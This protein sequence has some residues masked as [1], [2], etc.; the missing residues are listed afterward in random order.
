MKAIYI[1]LTLILL[2]SCDKSEKR[3]EKKNAS[4][5]VHKNNLGEDDAVQK[6]AVNHYFQANGGTILYLKNGEIKGCA[7]CD[8]DGDLITELLK[9]E[10]Y[11]TYK[12]YDNYLVDKTNDTLFFFDDYGKILPDWKIL[13]GV[14]VTNNSMVISFFP[15][16]KTASE[17]VQKITETCLVIFNP[18]VK[19]FEDEN[20][21]EAEAYF[22][23][24]DDWNWYSHELNEYFKKRNVQTI[25]ATGP[26]SLA[27]E[28]N[29]MITIDPKNKINNSNVNAILY[30]KRKRPIIVSLIPNDNDTAE[31]DRYLQ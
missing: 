11:S 28:D 4:E 24:M 13:K 29:K 2:T 30:K 12:S 26:I 1:L 16:K 25:Y 14:E 18:E 8:S 6:E 17:K 10:T 19:T 27:I 20:S 3:I 23:A 22:T 21:S 5:A 7:K 31:I 9:T 15:P